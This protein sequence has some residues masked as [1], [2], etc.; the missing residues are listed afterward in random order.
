[1]GPIMVIEIN[2]GNIHPQKTIGEG[3]N[4]VIVIILRQFLLREHAEVQTKSNHQSHHHKEARRKFFHA[5]TKHRQHPDLNT[6]NGSTH[7]KLKSPFPSVW[8]VS[9]LFLFGKD[10]DFF[11]NIFG[12]LGVNWLVLRQPPAL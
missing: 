6:A 1:M 11:H 9:I 8:P 10:N 4:P 2:T 3:R 5:V 7:K 12:L